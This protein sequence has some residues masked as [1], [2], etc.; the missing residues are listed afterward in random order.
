MTILY[1]LEVKCDQCRRELQWC[2]AAE[3]ANVLDFLNI[4]DRQCAY[5]TGQVADPSK[6]QPT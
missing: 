5:C 2:E 6:E 3:R 1:R 4:G